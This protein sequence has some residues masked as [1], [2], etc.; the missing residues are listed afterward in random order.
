MQV[1][2]EHLTVLTMDKYNQNDVSN[3]NLWK[4]EKVSLGKNEVS[5]HLQ[6]RDPQISFLSWKQQ[7]SDISYS[8]TCMNAIFMG[9][10]HEADNSYLSNFSSIKC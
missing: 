10:L 6:D 3:M 8:A 9:Q 7:Q 2:T 1:Y 5:V 4:R